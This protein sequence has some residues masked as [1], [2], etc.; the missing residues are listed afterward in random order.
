MTV[1][2][3][4]LTKDWNDTP[5]GTEFAVLQPGEDLVDERGTRKLAVDARRAAA[6]I[7]QKLAVAVSEKPEPD[8]EDAGDGGDGGDS[9]G[10]TSQP[11]E[12]PHRGRRPRRSKE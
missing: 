7:E 2:Q 8:D 1:K 12:T 9:E 5:K 4:R 11:A 3:I 10:D 6:L